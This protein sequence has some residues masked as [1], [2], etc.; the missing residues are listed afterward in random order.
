MN[1]CVSLKDHIRFNYKNKC[2]NPQTLS[3]LFILL[4]LKYFKLLKLM[5]FLETF[6]IYIFL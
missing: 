5:K 3:C 4:K 1:G 2:K 6:E